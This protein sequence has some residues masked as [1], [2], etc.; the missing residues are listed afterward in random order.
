[1]V[2]GDHPQAEVLTP[3]LQPFAIIHR[4]LCIFTGS[5]FGEE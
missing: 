5:V 3:H 4:H 1:M 2:E